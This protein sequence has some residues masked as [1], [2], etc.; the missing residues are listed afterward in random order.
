MKQIWKTFS[1]MSSQIFSFIVLHIAYI[2]GI[3][4]TAMVA[5]ILGKYFLIK[6]PLT[7]SWQ[8]RNHN[9]STETMY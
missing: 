3:G 6:D 1:R 2:I 9:K 8:K 4:I 5:K 7:T